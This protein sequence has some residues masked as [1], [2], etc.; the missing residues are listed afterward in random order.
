MKSLI[1]TLLATGVFSQFCEE[2][3]W[4]V[5]FRDDFNGD[6]LD[7]DNWEI[8]TSQGDSRVR[9]SCG[10]ADN[11]NVKNGTLIL[12]SKR[13]QPAGCKYNYTTG[14]VISQNK[15]YW[16]ADDVRVCVKAILPGKKGTAAGVWPAHWLMPNSND[17]WPT[18]G[19]IDIMEMI[20]GDGVLHG[21]YH[22]SPSK[23]G[24][25]HHCGSST[26]AETY[27]TQMHEYATQYNTS[28]VSFQLDSQTYF[29]SQSGQPELYALPY[30]ALLQTAL[31]G[32]WPGPVT[33]DT[34]FPIYH[35]ID[36]IIV[37]KKK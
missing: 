29:V 22:W 8:I 9:D 19:E 23:C 32:P 1:L 18:G 28:H 27:G 5:I 14:A 6:S 35:I 21:T 37:S 33:K 16:Q 26:P 36:S 34:A 11:V 3:G 25:D 20:N 12:S 15:K 7:M 4:E 10:T 30:Y 31:G 17:C 2:D 13:E 24:D